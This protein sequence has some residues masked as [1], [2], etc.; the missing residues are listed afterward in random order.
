MSNPAHAADVVAT[1]GLGRP[2]PQTEELRGRCGASSSIRHYLGAAYAMARSSGFAFF[3][4][5]ERRSTP[6]NAYPFHL[7]LNDLDRDWSFSSRRRQLSANVRVL[8]TWLEE[9]NA[10]PFAMLVGGSF[11]D[12]SVASP[13]DLDAVLYYMYAPISVVHLEELQAKSKVE[14]DIDVRMIPVDG[15]PLLVIRTAAYFGIL[16]SKIEGSMTIVRPP[17]YVDFS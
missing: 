17:L 7:R 11:A 9:T 3:P 10:A 6:L 1:D 8:L 15:D 2:T 14:L 5:G 12:R 16:Y 13:S 4:Q